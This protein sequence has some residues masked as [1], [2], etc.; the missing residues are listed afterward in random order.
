VGV[1]PQGRGDTLGSPGGTAQEEKSALK[2]KSCVWTLLL[3]REG[4]A[5]KRRRQLIMPQSDSLKSAQEKERGLFK[6]LLLS[7]VLTRTEKH[8]IPEK[9]DVWYSAEIDRPGK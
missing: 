6:W 8:K 7:A 3:S 9:C 1:T 5:L 4:H 2:A